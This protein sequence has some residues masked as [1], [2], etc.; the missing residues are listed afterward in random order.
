ML[1]LNLDTQ[2]TRSQLALNDGKASEDLTSNEM[3]TYRNRTNITTIA[4]GTSGP[5]QPGLL[6]LE[7]LISPNP[8]STDPYINNPDTDH[9]L[10]G[11]TATLPVR[12]QDVE[13][14][15]IASPSY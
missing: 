11:R 13:Q 12:V 6:L 9:A 8:R 15:R 14:A 10:L 1:I 2:I 4:D 5:S 3:A 7:T